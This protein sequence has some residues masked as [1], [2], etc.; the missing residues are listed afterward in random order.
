M[1]STGDPD[2]GAMAPRSIDEDG[3]KS[4]PLSSSQDV[5]M[6]SKEEPV[7]LQ[8]SHYGSR[9]GPRVSWRHEA[10]HG[11]VLFDIRCI[12]S[13]ARCLSCRYGQL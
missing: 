2:S 1:G 13:S 9:S 6:G 5:I 4:T 3:E 7:G 8:R 11:Y 10:L 12:L